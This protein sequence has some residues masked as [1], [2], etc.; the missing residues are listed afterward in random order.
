MYVLFDADHNFIFV[1]ASCQGQIPFRVL[2]DTVPDGVETKNLG[3]PNPEPLPYR[4]TIM[5]Y[6]IVADC[7]FAPLSDNVMNVLM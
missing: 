6:F 7:A 4:R 3:L 5:A 1:D 2:Q